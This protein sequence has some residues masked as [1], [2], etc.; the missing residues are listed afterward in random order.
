MDGESS[1]KIFLRHFEAEHADGHVG[2]GPD[3]LRDVQHEARLAHRRARR[4]DDQIRGLQPRRHLVEIGE[5]GRHAR[6]QLL[7]R[8]QLFDGVETRLREVAQRDEAVADL[9]VGDREDCVLRFVED[10]VG[11]LLGLVRVGQDLVRREDQVPEGRLL[12]DDPRV[13]VDVGRPRD[14]VDQRGDVRGA[15]DFVDLAGASELLLQ[16]DEIDGVAALDE[17]DHLLENPAMRVAEEIGRVDDL[18]GE[19]ERVVMQQDGAEDGPLGFEIVRKRPLGC[20]GGHWKLR[21]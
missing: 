6:D 8:V 12:L 15:A 17:R 3:V 16:R 14:A 18:G 10:D 7:A 4:D 2:L 20:G 21:S 5:A 19:V 9:V 11:V 13:V 1:M